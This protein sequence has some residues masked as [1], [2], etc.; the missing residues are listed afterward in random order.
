MANNIDIKKSYANAPDFEKE[1]YDSLIKMGYSVD[2]AAKFSFRPIEE[3]EAW[4]AEALRLM[5][6]FIDNSEPIQPIRNKG[7]DEIYIENMSRRS[8]LEAMHNLGTPDKLIEIL[9]M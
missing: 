4:R 2:V 8:I 5:T 6:E 9:T 3:V 7:V 1:Y